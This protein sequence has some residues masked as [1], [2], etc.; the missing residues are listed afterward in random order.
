MTSRSSFLA[1]IRANLPKPVDL[2]EDVYSH[3]QQVVPLVSFADEVAR[4]AHFETVLKGFGGIVVD[5]LSS[6]GSG[7]V[8]MSDTVAQHWSKQGWGRVVDL[9]VDPT[10]GT[11][12][13]PHD[14]HDVDIAIVRGQLAV[15]ENAAVWVSEPELGQRALY[16]LCQRLVLVVPRA[17]LVDNMRQA[18]EQLEFAPH[19]FGVFI[20]GSSR[21]ADIEQS[22]VL[23][24]HGAMA[25][26]VIF[27]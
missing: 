3:I 2:P 4:R 7:S 21:T 25:A 1:N 26:M 22:L 27:E 9:T 8:G 12:A 5:A 6:T 13:D 14:Y 19:G 10:G 11:C 15:A 18:Y 20:A 16:F 23:G 17:A 24:A